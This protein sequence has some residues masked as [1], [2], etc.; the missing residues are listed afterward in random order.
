MK[1]ALVAPPFLAVPPPKYGGTELFLHALCEGLVERGADVTLFA[2]GDSTS[3]ARVR[4][5]HREGTWPPDPMIELHHV[6]WA[7]GHIAGAGFDIVH[8]HSPMALAYQPFLGDTPLVYTI[9]HA[10]NASLSRYYRLY[11]DVGFVAISYRQKALEFGGDEVPVIHHG[12]IPAE[13]RPSF[14]AGEYLLY[15]GRIAKEKG[16]HLAIDAARLA[17]LPIVVAGAPHEPEQAY[18]RAEVKPRLELPGVSYVGE[19]GGEDKAALLRKA[20]A[21]VFPIQWDEPFGLVMVEAML[22]GTPIVGF[23]KG[24]APEVVDEGVTGHLVPTGDVHALA[25]AL[26]RC[27]RI[28]RRNC[29]ERAEIR[30]SHRRMAGEYLAL[31]HELLRRKEEQKLKSA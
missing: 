2:T 3:C 14:K 16:T 23:K 18:F 30:F 21:L 11:P 1:I 6:G 8:V 28:D 12:L 4:Y 25:Q 13:H 31:Y 9:H 27:G 19:V 17:G 22:S 29:R 26:K 10:R 15:L 7:M 5:Y 20:L 24:S